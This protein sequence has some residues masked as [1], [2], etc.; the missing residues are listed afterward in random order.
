MARARIIFR[1]KP[2]KTGIPALARC[3]GVLVCSCARV[4]MYVMR[5]VRGRKPTNAQRMPPPHAVLR[6]RRVGAIP[7]Q[8]S[9]GVGGLVG[10]WW[11]E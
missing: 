6:R 4:L 11:N 2:R 10:G 5:L 7:K 9:G 3:G 1:A 8:P